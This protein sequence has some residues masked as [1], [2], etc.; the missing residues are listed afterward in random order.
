MRV[1]KFGRD[2]RGEYHVGM[3]IF[4]LDRR[5][6]EVVVLCPLGHYIT[7]F[8]VRLLT[9]GYF[10]RPVRCYGSV[11]GVQTRLTDF[12]GGAGGE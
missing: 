1:V 5:N 9:L 2:E 8:P 4:R 10:R 6:D 12:T 11:G 7:S 3:S